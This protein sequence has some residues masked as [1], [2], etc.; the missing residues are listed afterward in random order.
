MAWQIMIMTKTK[1]TMMWILAAP[2][3]MPALTTLLQEI[4]LRHAP[5]DPVA[6]RAIYPD[7]NSRKIQSATKSHHRLQIA[8]TGVEK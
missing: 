8:V 1:T 2:R 4:L 3:Q 6:S 5:R 7:A